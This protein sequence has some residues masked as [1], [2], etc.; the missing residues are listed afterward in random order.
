MTVYV[1]ICKSEYIPLYVFICACLDIY[2]FTDGE[3]EKLNYFG[4]LNRE[5]HLNWE[6]I[7]ACGSNTKYLLLSDSI[8]KL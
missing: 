5:P 3:R 6:K 2:V 8:S 4:S 7:K 1:C